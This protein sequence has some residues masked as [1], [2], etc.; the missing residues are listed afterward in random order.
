MKRIETV[1][2]YPTASQDAALHHALHVTRHLYNAAL[3][4]RKDAYRL[5]CVSVSMKMQYAEVTELRKE[6]AP[7]AGVYRESEDAVLRRLDLAMQ[8]FFRRCK[9]G[10]TPGVPRFKA[11][12]VAS[13]HVS[14]WRSR[15]EVRCHAAPRPDSRY[16]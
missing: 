6:S 13:D 11:P 15:A 3:Q 8:A 9:Q 5:R 14:A 12:P 16:W 1:R 4:Q 10:E 7:L 2:L